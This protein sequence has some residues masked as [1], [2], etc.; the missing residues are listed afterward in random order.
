VFHQQFAYKP[1]LKTDIH[2]LRETDPD[3]A[4]YFFMTHAALRKKCG[5]SHSIS[6]AIRWPSNE[7]VFL[8]PIRID[9]AELKVKSH[10]RTL[11]FTKPINSE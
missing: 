9:C 10:K 8:I 1:F 4:Q 11:T 5:E 6:Y 7:I 3:I 2:I